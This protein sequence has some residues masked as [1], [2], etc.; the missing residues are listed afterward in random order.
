MKNSLKYLL[1]A[2]CISILFSP[3]TLRADDSEDSPERA[4][5][6][7]PDA[8]VVD[9]GHYEVEAG[10]SY[11]WASRQWDADGNDQSRGFVSD[12]TMSL[13]A[14]VGIANNLDVGIATTYSWLFD[15]DNDFD[16][17]GV[18]GPRTGRGIGGLEIGAR[19]RFIQ[20]EQQNLDVAYVGSLMLPTGTE[21]NQNKIGTSQEYWSLNQSLVVS[22]D[23]GRWT[24]NGDLGLALPFG[25]KGPTR[26]VLNA[27]LAGGYQLFPWLQ[28]EIEL[29]YA[30]EFVANSDDGDVIAITAGLV[31]PVTDTWRVNAGVQQGL[32]GANADKAT[33]VSLSVASAF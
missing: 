20:S 11:G 13:A 32:W 10:F 23:W 27:D 29:N 30:H 5:I 1:L 18:V 24:A 14:T 7:T 6:N 26:G 17:D 3:Q 31:M 25:K 15:K 33:I 2:M 4:K 12:H 9:P 16:G 19:Y 28:S 22:K 8:S 21:S